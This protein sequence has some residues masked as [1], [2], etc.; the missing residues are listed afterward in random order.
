MGGLAVLLL[1]GFYLWGAY[2]IVRLAKPRWAK[3]LVILVVILIP[4]ADAVYG[5]IKLR[6]M[7]AAEG[8]FKI[9]HVASGVDGFLIDQGASDFWIKQYGYQYN[10]GGER[11][12]Q[13]VN[14]YVLRDGAIA[15]EWNVPS[16]ARYEARFVRPNMREQF[17]RDEY[18][19]RDRKNDEVLGKYVQI[20]F[21][22]GWAEQMLRGFS[23][24]GAGWA[25]SCGQQDPR[26]FESLILKT[27][28]PTPNIKGE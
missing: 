13:R 14:R 3:A 12:D 20:G 17:E 19:V 16:L 15:L 28:K 7:C 11:P 22:G 10:E 4:T 5:R 25:A 8:G 2:K 26:I 27:L 6:Q 23:D 18:L 24:A 1:L 9:N 21:R